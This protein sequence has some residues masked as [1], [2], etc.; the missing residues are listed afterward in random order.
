MRLDAVMHRVVVVTVIHRGAPVGGRLAAQ[1]RQEAAA[2]H[3]GGRLLAGGVQ[4]HRRE[5]H[6]EDHLVVHRARLDAAGPADDE[7][8]PQRFLIHEALVEPVVVAEVEALVG[9]VDDDGVVGESL[10]V[11]EVEQPADVV[12]HRGDAAQVVLDVALIFPF[13]QRVAG[14]FL[15]FAVDGDFHLRVHAGEPL[16][17]R[18]ALQLR[19]GQGILQVAPGQVA[20]NPHRRLR[21]GGAA[22]SI[23]VVE[24]GR[25]RDVHAV[26]H[27]RVLLVRLPLAVRR[28]LV[29]HQEERLVLR[30]VLDEVDGEIRDE[31]GDVAGVLLAAGRRE[32]DRVVIHALTGQNVPEIEAR[33]LAAEVPLADHAGVIAGG[34]QIR[35]QRRPLRVNRVE[36]RHAVDVTVLAGENARAARRADGVDAETIFEPH[37]GVGDAVEV[38]RLVDEAAVAT[39]GMR[40]V[41]VG[42]DV[43]DVRPGRIGGDSGQ[44]QQRGQQDSE[45]R[46]CS[47][48]DNSAVQLLSSCITPRA[49]WQCDCQIG[50][51]SV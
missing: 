39:H 38:R 19:W 23:V 42:H 37:P 46:F 4:Q 1:Q 24:R 8:H 27:V 29:A 33:R 20:V 9:G 30:A 50:S 26:I 34:V 22:G 25:L 14:Q 36:Y 40:R 11:E 17:A 7:R 10:A 5:V 41:V 49:R 47:H 35:R 28:L 13:L 31:V 18:A 32:E 3:V 16:D 21:R 43:E 48:D 15:L 6:V 51:G 44:R 45:K 12:V 2:L